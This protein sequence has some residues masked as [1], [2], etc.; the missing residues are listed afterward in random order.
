LGIQFQF[1]FF[2]LVFV[3]A[4]PVLAVTNPMF[5]TY[6]E[7]FCSAYRRYHRHTLGVVNNKS[8]KSNTVG[9]LSITK[10]APHIEFRH[11]DEYKRAGSILE[12]VS[13]HA[14]Q[15]QKQQ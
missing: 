6:G 9:K 13:F 12:R 15:L 8:K 11:A 1:F 3:D 2:P 10:L 5:T 4:I 7:L 14:Q